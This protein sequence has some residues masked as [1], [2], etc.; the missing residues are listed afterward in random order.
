MFTARRTAELI[1]YAANA[2]LATRSPSQRDG[3]PRGKGRRRRPGRRARH[4]ARH[5]IG[6][7]FLHAGPGFGGS[8]FRKT[9]ALWSRSRSIMTCPCGSSEAVLAVND[10]RQAAAMAARFPAPSAAACAARPCGAR[11]YLQAR[12]RDL[13]EAPS[14]RWLRPAR[15]G[16]ESARARS[17]RHGN[18]HGA[19]CPISNIA[20]IPTPAPAA[21][22]RWVIVTE[23][24]VPRARSERIQARDGAA[25]H[26]RPAQCLPS[27]D[28][29]ALGFY[30]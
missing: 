29:A 24:S 23:W 25:C 22:T 26:H 8:C 4:R 11:A 7:K 19:N 13:R 18:R 15:H 6:S 3:G 30:L 27:E 20:T 12:Y 10:N 16:R 17:V 28:M 2:F 9:P 1:K 14:I 21:P 5:R